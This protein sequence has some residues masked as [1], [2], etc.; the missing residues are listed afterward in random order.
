MNK[1]ETTRGNALPLESRMHYADCRCFDRNG[2]PRISDPADGYPVPC[3][4]NFTA[5]RNAWWADRR[6]ERPRLRLILAAELLA[7]SAS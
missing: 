3:D 4:P 1:Q 2:E 5:K 7:G 6:G